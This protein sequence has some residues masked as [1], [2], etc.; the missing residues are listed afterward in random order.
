[1]DPTNSNNDVK[2]QEDG[3]NPIASQD[4]G[5]IQEKNEADP[6][7]RE[8]LDEDGPYPPFAK[9]LMIMIAL[10]LALFIVALVS[11]PICHSINHDKVYSD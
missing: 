8:D 6:S 7:V 5:L 1:M 11:L 3:N 4:A 2:T 9:V 10:Y